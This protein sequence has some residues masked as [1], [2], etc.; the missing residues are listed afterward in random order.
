MR[1]AVVGALVSLAGCATSG[2]NDTPIPDAGD[3]ASS[4]DAGTTSETGD[5]PYDSANDAGPPP[6][7]LSDWWAGR[8]RWRLDRTYTLATT[9]WP[10]GYGAGAHIT[11]AGGAWYLFSRRIATSA[12]PSYC[13]SGLGKQLSTEV[14]KSTDRGVTWSDPVEIIPTTQGTKWE[15]AA[16][17]GDAIYDAAT[18]KWH[19]LFQCLDRSGTWNGCH[20]ERSSVDPAGPFVETAPNPVIPAGSLWSKIC[21]QPAD[22]CVSIPGGTGKVHDEGTFNIFLHDATHYW[23]GFHGFDGTN[24]YRG[25]AKSPDFATWIAGDTTQGLPTDAI[26]DKNDA[27]AW[28]E[29]WQSGGPIGGGAGSILDE[30][31]YYYSIVETGDVSLGCVDGQ[32]WDWGVFRTQ[33]LASATWE[34]LPAQN[35]FL[36]SSKL[37]ERNGKS[38]ACNPAYGRLFREPDGTIHLHATRESVDPAFDGIFLWTLVPDANLLDDGDLWKCLTPPW[39]KFALGPTNLVVYRYPNGSSDGNCYLAT[40]CGQATCQQGQSVYQDVTVSNLGGKTLAFGGK[41]ATD[42]ATG[43]LDVVVHELDA[44]STTLATHKVSIVPTPTYAPASGRATLDARTTTLRYQLVL[45]SAETFR[46]DEMYLRI[47]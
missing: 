3:D 10:Y 38:I 33:S 29:Q 1:F 23:I 4:S 17:D 18:T 9:G 13:P 37:L 36:Y 44:Q 32:D 21:N 47:E 30:G 43:M 12:L 41:F 16:T 2:T 45:G 39:T 28:R 25:I 22:D 26:F 20:V 5:A 6:A 24:G 31:G 7:K 11:I 34:G 27:V 14:R 19:Y 42:S 40:N 35:P 15:C 8:A 46:A